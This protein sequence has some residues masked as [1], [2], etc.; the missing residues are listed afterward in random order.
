MSETKNRKFKVLGAGW[1]GL[2]GIFLALAFIAFV[3]VVLG[4]DSAGQAFEAGNKWWIVVLVLL[5]IGAV[6]MVPGSALLRRNPVARPLLIVSSLVLLIPST[7]GVVAAGDVVNLVGALLVVVPSLWL[8]LSKGG[9]KAYESYMARAEGMSKWHRAREP[10][11]LPCVCG[12]RRKK[13]LTSPERFD[14][15]ETEQGE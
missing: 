14:V 2:G 4:D 3:S 12:S 10:H 8:T 13:S 15:D 6:L 11:P 7:V 9:K 5:G 1:L